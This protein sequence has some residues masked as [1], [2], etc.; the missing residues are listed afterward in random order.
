MNESR[1]SNVIKN[2][3]AILFY[4]GSHI[5][6]QF[7]LRTIFIRFL[8]NE[9]TGISSLF[10]D[11]LS[12]LSLMELGIGSAML[13]ALY[14]PL[15][16]QNTQ[17][18]NAL[19]HFYKK[20]YRIIGVAV[21]LLGAACIPFLQYIVKDVPNIKE[22][23][24]VIFL[25]YVLNSACS[26]FLVYKT[27]LLR[28]DQKSRIISNVDTIIQIAETV[29]E[30][31]LLV[32]L[33]EYFA[34][35]VIHFIATLVRNIILS[36]I[37]QKKY[38]KYLTNSKTTLTKSD[39]KLL[40]KD[41]FALGIY[42]VSGVIVNSTDSIV[43]SAFVGTTQV[44]ILGN[45]TL[46]VRSIRIILEQIVEAVKPSVGNL[47]TLATKEKQEEVFR[48][49]NFLF[50]WI[51]CFCCTC[52]YV[53]LNPFVGEIWFDNS[54]KVEQ[55]L[56]I[57]MTI[58][59]F[60][61]VMVFPVEI[62][63]TANGL[64]V[65]GKYRPAIMAII[66]IILDIIF[67]QKWG[68]VG[69]YCATAISRLVTQCWFDPYLVFRFVFKKKP[70]KYY[71]QYI[72]YGLITIIS[73]L[74]TDFFANLLQIQSIYGSFLYKAIVALLVPNILLILLFGRKLEF[75]EIAYKIKRR[76]L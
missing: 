63:R 12:V 22:D 27:S 76:I 55:A 14:E 16:A 75:K 41:I 44:A 74:I 43:I 33:R 17:R 49:I 47:A 73:C 6:A 11:I 25:F 1:T 50:F 39:T 29:I 45:F 65:Q 37:A 48:T 24:R 13:F 53:L 4:K 71:G 72:L 35:L 8:G 20:A 38:A 59:F 56:I 7:V 15:A 34:Y 68:I 69:V 5:I 18:V 46:I 61:A 62:F 51:A 31:I 58:N 21:F 66:N 32:L 26:Y 30:V 2:S 42:K 9:Y 19:M 70:W 36:R 60:I 57:I 28:A 40:F 10:T 3:G 52:F 54:Y 64:F 23:I 67:V